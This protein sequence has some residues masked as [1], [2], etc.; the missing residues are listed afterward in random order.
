MIELVVH[1]FAECDKEKT[2]IPAAD[3]HADQFITGITQHGAETI[4]DLDQ[5]SIAVKDMDAIAG[6][7][8]ESLVGV[9][10]T[11]QR[12]LVLAMLG[13]FPHQA[14]GIGG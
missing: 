12:N 14:Q 3:I 1:E 8:Q 2:G 5:V 7:T 10:L 13:Q 6:V 4:A 9:A 11:L